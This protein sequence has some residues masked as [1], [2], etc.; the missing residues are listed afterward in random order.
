MKLVTRYAFE[1]D[2]TQ[3]KETTIFDDGEKGAVI[4]SY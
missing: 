4:V 3:W 1:K 2:L